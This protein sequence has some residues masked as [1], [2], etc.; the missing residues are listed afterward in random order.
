[1]LVKYL[2]FYVIIGNSMAKHIIFDLGNVLIHTHPELAM[3][4]FEEAC[5]LR[6]EEIKEFYL[7]D[8]HL[9]FMNGI[10]STREFYQAMVDEYS[11]SLDI[12]HF[13]RIW[14]RVIGQAKDGI[15][16]VIE[17]LK[18]SYTLVLCSNTDPWHWQKVLQEI[19]FMK[20][21][22]QFF[23]SFEMKLNKP[24]AQVFKYIL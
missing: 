12:F 18:L 21:F 9:G 16:E 8:L 10:Y 22:E 24:D 17:E 15:H 11:I 23:L 2:Y 13:K 19:P 20:E 4:G 5:G 6:Q 14:N 1:M 7:S 3:K